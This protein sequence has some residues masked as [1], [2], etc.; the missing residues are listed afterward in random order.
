MPSDPGFVDISIRPRDG[1]SFPWVVLTNRV[2][3]PSDGSDAGVQVTLNVADV[4]IP[5]PSRYT[6]AGAG[7]LTDSAGNPIVHA[8]VRAY[9]FPPVA[10]GVDGGTPQARPWLYNVWRQGMEGGRLRTP[11]STR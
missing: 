4:V 3:P 7:V 5:E 8:V 11:A 6:Q 9:A 1:T 2:V 10:T